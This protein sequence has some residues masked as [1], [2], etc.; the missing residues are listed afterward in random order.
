MRLGRLVITTLLVFGAPV[1]ALERPVPIEIPI[2][3]ETGDPG[4]WVV[5]STCEVVYFNRCISTLQGFNPEFPTDTFGVVFG[6]CAPGAILDGVW[7]YAPGFAPAGWGYTGYISTHEVDANDAPVRPA[8]E[9][10]PFLSASQ[11]SFY[12]FDTTVPERFVV[13]VEYH[14]AIQGG[15][16]LVL[17]HWACGH[18][19][20]PHSYYYGTASEPLSPGIP[21]VT[22]SGTYNELL[23]RAAISAP[24]GIPHAAWSDIKNLYR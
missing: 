7:I 19:P 11:W 17:D 5:A 18:P 2:T 8:I 1:R 16:Y 12:D 14:G 4:G 23:W 9:R 20:P 15:H 10:R 24:T 22:G 21:F 3:E 6:A 13:T